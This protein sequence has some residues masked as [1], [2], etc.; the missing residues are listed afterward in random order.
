MFTEGI[1][2]VAILETAWKKLYAEAPC[3]FEIAQAFD[4]SFLRNLMKRQ[5]LYDGHPGRKFFSLFDFDGAYDDWRQLGNE[6]E[7]DVAR[8]LTRQRENCQSYAMLIPVALSHV[9]RNQV[10]RPDG[11]VFGSQARFAIELLFYGIPGLEGHFARDVTELAQPVKFIGDKVHFAQHVV[12]GLDAQHF[13]PFRP[14]FDFIN[15]KIA[16]D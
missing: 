8:C 3:P 11:Q 4:C 12:S 15:A 10:I 1:S 5:T 6:I 2:D 13:E 7:A 9:L 14:I 16:E